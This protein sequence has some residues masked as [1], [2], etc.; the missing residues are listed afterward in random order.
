ME[1]PSQ[2]SS[3]ARAV[4]LHACENYSGVDSGS[5]P[6]A[7]CAIKRR[8][9]LGLLRRPR[10]STRMFRFLTITARQAEVAETNCGSAAKVAAGAKPP[11]L[12]P[13][14]AMIGTEHLRASRQWRPLY[15]YGMQTE[16]TYICTIATA[17]CPWHRF[18]VISGR[19]R[20]HLSPNGSN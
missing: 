1:E 20:W 19:P 2:R 12:G 3:L 11:A 15:S 7:C 5:E 16:D 18:P 9:F 10:P 4:W 8:S 6:L 17:G 13:T 14:L